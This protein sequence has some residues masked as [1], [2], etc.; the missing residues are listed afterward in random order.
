MIPDY[1]STTWTAIGAAVGNHLWQSTLFAI[2]AGL[3]T[4][5]LR[6]N[7]ARARYWVWLAASMKFLIP[8]SL[9]VGIG[10]HLAWSSGQ[11]ET[12]TGGLFFAMEQASQPFSEPAMPVMSRSAAPIVT[13]TSNHFIPELLAAAWVCGFLIVMGVWCVG[14]RRIAA[15][16]REAARLTEGREVEAL[17]RVARMGGMQG[18]IEMRLSRTP[19]EPG[20]FGVAWPVLLWPE[21]ISERFDNAHLEAILAHELWHVRRRDNLA[22]GM[23][24][25]VEAIFWF[26]PMVWWMGARL[27]EERERACDEAVLEMGSAPQVYAESILKT[28]EFCVSSRLA[29]VSGV[30]GAG[31]K[32]RIVRVM[33]EG[34]AKRLNFGRR[35]LL[36]AAGLLAVA[37]PVVFGALHARQ[38]AADTQAQDSTGPAPTYEVA[39]IKPNKSGLNMVRMMFTPDGLN[40]NGATLDMLIKSAYGIE[41]NQISGEPSWIKSNKYDI[42]AKM[43]GAEAQALGKLSRDEQRPVREKMLQALLADRF[44]LVIHR[45]TKELPVYALVVAKNGPKLHES[46]PGDTYSAGMKGIDGRP[47]G[48]GM[49]MMRGNGGPLTGQGIPIANL[50][51]VLSMQLGRTVIDKTGL[52]GKYDFTLQWTP[53][54]SQGP[55][56]GG[57]G[58]GGGGQGPGGAPPPDSNGPSIFTAIQEQLGL[59]LESEKGPVEIIV[60]DH[61][62]KPSEN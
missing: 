31:L 35:L 45:E 1:L 47:A 43:D 51:H 10:S 15:V 20:I 25:G 41:D 36:G 46:K 32:K 3:L 21:G 48:A 33:T 27:V 2:A 40:S 42:E 28:C 39:S 61:V 37:A 50:A 54:E 29:C 26:H 30:T 8:F 58:P 7:R 6:K 56:M 62:E 19:S 11:A 49:M 5:I 52:T 60:I 57:P 44:K 12:T 53:D 17:R 55:V 38:G 13:A 16:V 59:K 22:A 24:M 23:H 18:R 34:V 4:L 9:L 14:W